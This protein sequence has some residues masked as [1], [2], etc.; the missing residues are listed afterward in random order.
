MNL[1]TV[2]EAFHISLRR[3]PQPR[4]QTAP[5]HIISQPD[6][7]GELLRELQPATK[8]PG[9]IRFSVRR[10]PKSQPQYAFK[11]ALDAPGFQRHF[12]QSG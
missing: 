2:A 10:V 4:I 12:A 8:F 1:R 3:N 11:R 9:A 5:L 6:H 7:H